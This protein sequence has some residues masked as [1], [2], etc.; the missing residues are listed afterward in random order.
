MAPLS[1]LGSC[2]YSRT[3]NRIGNANAG[4]NRNGMVVLDHSHEGMP[5]RYIGQPIFE[6][7]AKQI[8]IVV[9]D[10]YRRHTWRYV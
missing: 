3:V 1:I 6:S 2:F 5:V 4:T 8:G 7:A 9:A 10:R